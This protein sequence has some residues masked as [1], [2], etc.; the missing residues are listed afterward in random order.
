MGVFIFQNGS[1]SGWKRI[2][3]SRQI[4]PSAV[5]FGFILAGLLGTYFL[6]TR[7]ID[8]PRTLPDSARASESYR[9]LPTLT[10]VSVKRRATLILIPAGTVQIGDNNGPSAERP[11]FEFRSR[12][13]L[14][15][16]TP[17]TV[18]QFA[19]FVKVTRYKTDAERYGFGGHLEKSSGA[20]VA[21]PGASWRYPLGP[22]RSPALD[23]HPVTQVSW[24]DANEFCRAYGL[25]LPTESE[26]ERAARMGQTPD[27]HV[28]KAGDP[29][30]LSHRYLLNAWE[31]TFPL[32]NTGADGYQTTSPVGAFGVTPSGLTDMAGNVWEWTSSRYLPYGAPQQESTR[33]PAEMVSRGGSFLCSPEF[34]QG[35]R[36]SARNHTTPDTSLEN[37]GFRCAAD[38]GLPTESRKESQ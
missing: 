9:L 35:Y 29:I 8:A 33:I 10:A 6:M 26:W 13:F 4:W 21:V 32:A 17:V 16:R 38:P 12:A 5:Y 11:A 19:D 3:R 15:D 14:M 28:F 22:K 25:R 23:D 24:F 36:A 1:N 7:L 34:C 31:G 37:I 18:S 30:E 2:D 20:W 27:G